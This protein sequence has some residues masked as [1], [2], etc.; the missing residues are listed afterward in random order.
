MK[1]PKEVS[2]A[3]AFDAQSRLLRGCPTP[4]T[5]QDAL[6][7]VCAYVESLEAELAVARKVVNAAR[8]FA[9][10]V[11]EDPEGECQYDRGLLKN[12]NRV[13]DSYDARTK[14]AP[15]RG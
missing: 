10:D 12:L 8:A 4:N 1:R 11:E 6:M 3:I 15:T 14:E 2:E 5:A 9:E 13:L 7:T